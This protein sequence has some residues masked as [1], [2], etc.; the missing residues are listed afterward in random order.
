MESGK[1]SE[2]ERPTTSYGGRTGVRSSDLS[3]ASHKDMK[4]HGTKRN[5]TSTQHRKAGPGNKN[6]DL[7]EG[8]ETKI[9]VMVDKKRGEC[10]KLKF[11]LHQKQDEVEK[12][13]ITLHDLMQDSEALGLNKYPDAQDR[14]QPVTSVSRRPVYAKE[15]KIHDLQKQ[16]EMKVHEG[17]IIARKSWTYE[18]MIKRLESEKNQRI[19]ENNQLQDRIREFHQKELDVHKVEIASVENLGSCIYYPALM[20]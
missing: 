4:S 18:H 14:L 11:T 5:N 2:Q 9:R 8:L 19:L 3:A 20:C 10:D 7:V 16:L 15:T 13:K 17:K 12:L 1:S 6:A